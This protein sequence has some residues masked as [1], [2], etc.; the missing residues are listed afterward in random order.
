MIEAIAEAMRE[1][2][3]RQILKAS[4]IRCFYLNERVYKT[5]C[6]VDLLA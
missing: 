2:I 5:D 1:H 6:S 3:R 4:F